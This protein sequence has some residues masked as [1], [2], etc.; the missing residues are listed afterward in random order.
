MSPKS[1]LSFPHSS[2]LRPHSSLV[3]PQS[4][5]LRPQSSVPSSIDI[6]PEYCCMAL[7]LLDS[8]PGPLFAQASI[9]YRTA[10]DLFS[11][12]TAIAVADAPARE[13][14]RSR[15]ARRGLDV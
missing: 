2:I 12:A 5:I 11:P 13:L 3:S 15:R 10:A 1:P 14:A 9:E 4:S 6:D 8:E 7:R